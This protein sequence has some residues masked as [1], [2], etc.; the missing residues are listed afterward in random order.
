M[1]PATLS[2]STISATCTAPIMKNAM[3][4]CGSIWPGAAVSAPRIGTASSSITLPPSTANNGAS[5]HRVNPLTQPVNRPRVP[6]NSAS[7]TN[8]GPSAISTPSAILVVTSRPT[9]PSMNRSAPNHIM[10]SGEKVEMSSAP[11]LASW[12]ARKT[13]SIFCAKVSVAE[14]CAPVSTPA[15]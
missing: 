5:A 1:A 6:L 10:P 13:T 2:T 3:A 12:M 11:A 4:A 15:R 8:S 14:P 9:V 7:T